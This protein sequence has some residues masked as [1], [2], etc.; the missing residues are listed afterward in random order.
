[1]APTIKDTIELL[2][3]A[4]KTAVAK[5]ET[6]QHPNPARRTHPQIW[7][8]GPQIVDCQPPENKPCYPTRELGEQNPD[9]TYPVTIVDVIFD[10]GSGVK[11]VVAMV[12]GD[13]EFEADDIGLPQY[14]F[15][16]VVNLYPGTYTL[17][18]DA[19]DYADHDLHKERLL[20][21]EDPV[22]SPPPKPPGV[23]GMTGWGIIASVVAVAGLMLVVVRRRGREM[24][25]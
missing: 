17:T 5:D 20:I 2:K 13:V 8:R 22:P 6:A 7:D 23:P 3:A 11:R 14:E 4:F 9:E 24:R 10:S 21:V 15:S 18:I 19:W 12:D 16:F 25:E 1:M